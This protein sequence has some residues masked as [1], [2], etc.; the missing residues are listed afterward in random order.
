MRFLDMP[1]NTHNKNKGDFMRDEFQTHFWWITEKWLKRPLSDFFEVGSTEYAILTRFSEGWGTRDTVELLTELTAKYGDVAGRAVEKY[2]EL[3]VLKDWAE[4][5]KKEAHEGTE[6]E[7]LIR[8]LLGFMKEERG[9]EF[10]MKRE[11]GTVT[12]CVT[13]CPVHELAEKTGM[14]E[15]LYHLAC[16]TD[17]HVARAFSAK[18]GLTR[19][20]TLMHSQECCNHRYYYRTER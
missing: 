2:A 4:I 14:H 3:N 11:K 8:V 18:I 16:S 6:L 7:D 1:K 9:L 20:K 15:W 10:T 17:F 13:K 12:F 19:T 5:G